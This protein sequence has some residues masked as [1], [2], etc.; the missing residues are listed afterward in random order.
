MVDLSGAAGLFSA[1]IVNPLIWLLIIGVFIILSFGLL[2]VRKRRMLKYSAAEIVDLGGQGKTNINFLGRRAAGY[3]GKQKWLFGYW[4][5]G[6][7]V[8][9]TKDGEIIEQFSE[10]DFQE[11]NGERGVI[12]YRDPVRRLLFP[13]NR[14]QIGNKHLTAVI[15]PAEYTDAAIDIIKA[16]E[17]ETADWREKLMQFVGWALVV[18]FSLV[19]IIV[20]TQMVKQGQAETAKLIADGGKQCM[21]LAKGVCSDMINQFSLRSTAP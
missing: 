7:K 9:K 4:D 10:E 18:I 19:A 11:V 12:F 21:E 1:W 16:A 20:I 5:F 2:L 6:E 15:A 8:M 17:K 3:F 14:L 13:I